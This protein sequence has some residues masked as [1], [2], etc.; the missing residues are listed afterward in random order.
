MKALTD[1]IIDALKEAKETANSKDYGR[2]IDQAIFRIEEMEKDA[3]FEEI[4]RIMMR[5]LA[6]PEK[7]HPHHRVIIDSTNAELL[8]GKE[9]TGQIMDYIPD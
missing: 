5:H 3:K 8:E 1:K 4:A 6:N 7:Y 9:S 2:G